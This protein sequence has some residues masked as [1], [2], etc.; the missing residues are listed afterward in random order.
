MLRDEGTDAGANASQLP[1][2]IASIEQMVRSVFPNFD[3]RDPK[4]DP[5]IRQLRSQHQQPV[6]STT[7]PGSPLVIPVGGAAG[8]ESVFAFPSMPFGSDVSQQPD[9]TYPWGIASEEQVDFTA[10][11]LGWDIDFGTMNMEA[12]LSLDPNEAFNFTS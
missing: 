5:D 10:A 12:F 3:P 6:H 7:I 4:V 9:G 1:M 8:E 2:T 11:D